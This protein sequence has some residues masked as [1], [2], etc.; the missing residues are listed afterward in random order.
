MRFVAPGAGMIE[1]QSLDTGLSLTLGRTS[2]LVRDA[3]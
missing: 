2:S 3:I 1:A